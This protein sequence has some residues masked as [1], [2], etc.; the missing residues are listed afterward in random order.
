MFSRL[1]LYG[2]A[3]ILAL[4]GYFFFSMADVSAKILSV[5]YPIS[6]CLFVPALIA[7]IGIILRIFI[8]RGQQGFKTQHLKLHLLRGTVI[9]VMVVLC[10]NSLKLIPI[11]DFYCIVFL[12]PFMVMALSVFL[13]KEEIHWPRILVLISSFTGVIITIGPH[14]NDWNIGYIFACSAMILGSTNV[15]LVRKIGRHEY[16]P[17]FGLFPLLGVVIF[18]MPFAVDNIVNHISFSKMPPAD[19][20]IFLFYGGSLIAAHNFLPIAFARTP[21]VSKLTPLHYSQMIWGILA[22]FFVFDSGIEWNT[23]LGGGLIIS[24]GLWLFYYETL[25]RKTP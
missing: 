5:R 7:S 19:I 22:G 13:Y 8:G 24:S 10:V 16:P 21:S 12:S 4:T 25:R 17:I 18:S 15:F 20:A 1:S 3:V 14:F 9:T 23:L 2:Q 11:A 6:F